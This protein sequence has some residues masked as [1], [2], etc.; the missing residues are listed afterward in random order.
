VTDPADRIALRLNGRPK[1]V[2][3]TTPF[4]P[5]WPGTTVL[6][7]DVAGQVAKLIQE[8]GDEP[9]LLVGS[10][11]LAQT[12]AAHDL[13]DEYQLMV[14]PVVLG[15]GKRLFGDR[16]GDRVGL[17]PVDSTTTEG[18]GDLPPRE[19]RARDAAVHCNRGTRRHR[20]RA[21]PRRPASSRLRRCR[22][23]RSCPGGAGGM[24]RMQ[25]NSEFLLARLLPTTIGHAR[26]AMGWVPRGRKLSRSYLALQGLPAGRRPCHGTPLLAR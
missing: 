14:H 23:P 8:S 20:P 1:Y 6:T 13:V 24:A 12:L 22:T 11:R 18:G 26:T 5:T 9:I 3:S 4:E 2:A 25:A 15:S 21:T 16:T 19:G 7:G 17:R 10:A